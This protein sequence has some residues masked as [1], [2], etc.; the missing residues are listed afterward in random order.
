M[1]LALL[2]SAQLMS[3]AKEVKLVL[4]VGSV[5]KSKKPVAPRTKAIVAGMHVFLPSQV[6]AKSVST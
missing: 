5:A 6:F 4:K 3:S 2:Q 1:R